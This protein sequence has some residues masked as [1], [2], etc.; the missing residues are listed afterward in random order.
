MT[1]REIS[2]RVGL[3]QM[4]VSRLISSSIAELSQL[5]SDDPRTPRRTLL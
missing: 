4:H 2:Q 1:Q 3:S 5:A